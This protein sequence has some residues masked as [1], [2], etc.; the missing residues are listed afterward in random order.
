MKKRKKIFNTKDI[1]DSWTDNPFANVK[2]TSLD[3]TNRVIKGV[4]VFGRRESLNGYTYTD[5]AIDSLVNFTNGAKFFIDHPSKSSIKE[6]DGVRP[7]SKWAG[8]FF[9]ARKEG[10]EKVYADLKVRSAY[11]DLLEDVATMMPEGIGCSINSRVKVYTDDKGN[12][13]ILDIDYLKS[14]DLV[15]QAATTVSLFE[16]L[17]DTTS[18]EDEQD[19]EAFTAEGILTDKLRQRE[20]SRAINELQYSASDLI[21]EIL[22]DQEKAFTDKKNEILSILD[23]LEKEI[24]KILKSGKVPATEQIT[25]ITNKEDDMDWKDITIELLSKERPDIIDDIRASLK[26]AEHVQKTEKELEETK[27]RLEELEG[28]VKELSK[29]NEDLKKENEDLK[30]KLDE[31][32]TK[33]KAAKKEALIKQKMEELKLPKDAVSEVFV[34]D[35]MLKEKEEEITEAIKDRKELWEKGQS[36]IKGAGEEYHF[37]DER[38]GDK[39][40]EVKESFI[41]QIKG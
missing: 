15:S 11:W 31:Y 33:E 1:V 32:E 39:L 6:T 22:R 37:A 25:N 23:D 36:K 34:K 20:L 24:A 35:L 28:K 3:P 16:H 9:N 38:S 26:D 40:K 21:D 29:E 10:D 8:V 19:E 2:E 14:I 18:E 4:C 27:V 30:K 12:E 17:P 5:K 41:K 7:M 13:S